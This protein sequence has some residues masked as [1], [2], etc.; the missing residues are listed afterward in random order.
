MCSAISRSLSAATCPSQER[1]AHGPNYLVQLLGARRAPL[2]DARG[3]RHTFINTTS[4]QLACC[5]ASDLNF[6]ASATHL[7]HFPWYIFTKP[8]RDFSSVEVKSPRFLASTS[9]FS[10]ELKEL[11]EAHRRLPTFSRSPGA[12]HGAR[13]FGAPLALENESPPFL[14]ANGATPENPSAVQDNIDRINTFTITPRIVLEASICAATPR[15]LR[16]Q[17]RGLTDSVKIPNPSTPRLRNNNTFLKSGQFGAPSRSVW[18]SSAGE[19]VCDEQ[20]TQSHPRHGANDPSY[21]CVQVIACPT[22]VSFLC[23]AL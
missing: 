21:D 23:V 18:F 16:P 20:S 12:A 14:S 5:S 11:V 8:M 3:V 2:G 13:T 7:R 9:A 17:P 1:L 6:G 4:P 22:H 10:T 15:G 19:G